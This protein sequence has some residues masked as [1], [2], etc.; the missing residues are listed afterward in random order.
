MARQGIV[1][2]RRVGVAILATGA[3]TC[4]AIDLYD[5]HVFG[6]SAQA[7]SLLLLLSSVLGAVII[8]IVGLAFSWRLPVDLQNSLIKVR[9]LSLRQRLRWQSVKVELYLS[10]TFFSWI[11]ILLLYIIWCCW[12]DIIPLAAMMAFLA[13]FMSHL[14]PWVTMQWQHERDRGTIE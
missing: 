2:N 12:M 7:P 9:A 4:V 10:L 3:L 8:S 5:R 13:L 11:Y 1:T 14:P 6:F